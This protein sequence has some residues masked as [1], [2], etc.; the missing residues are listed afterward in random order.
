MFRRGAILQPVLLAAVLALGL[1]VAWAIGLGYCLSVLQQFGQDDWVYEYVGIGMDGTPFVYSNIYDDYQDTIY[2]TL[3]GETLSEE[4]AGSLHWLQG[5]PLA[6]PKG[7][8]MRWGRVGWMSRILPTADFRRP[9][10]YWYFVHSGRAKGTAYLV[11]YDPHSKLRVGYIGRKGFRRDMPPPE[12]R[13]P[14]GRRMGVY[15]DYSEISILADRFGYEPTSSPA[16]AV[17]GRIPPWMIYLISGDRLVEI[18]LRTHSVRDVLDSPGLVSIGRAERGVPSLPDQAT[19]QRPALRQNLAVRTEDQVLIVD[20]EGGQRRSYRLPPEICHAKFT[21]FELSDGTALAHRERRSGEGTTEHFLLWIDEAGKT[22]RREQLTLKS[23]T[24]SAWDPRVEACL[25]ALAIPSPL[26]MTVGTTV[27]SPLQHLTSGRE[28][29]Y[30]SA[31]AR[32][33]RKEW[34]ALALTYVLGALL[35]WVCS[36]RQR[37]HGLGGSTAWVVFVFLFG[38]PGLLGYLFCR[39]WP[40]R[41]ACPACG[42]DAPRDRETCFACGADF[43]EPVLKGTEVFA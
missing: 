19:E 38:L 33:L 21:F 29:T 24:P 7:P 40:A 6:G 26:A 2:H 17:P 5:A 16:A 25:P 13:F 37:R 10:T 8:R 4:Q 34:P 15:G 27:F 18:D 20:P 23:G 35:A 3:E 32:S 36:R 14:V 31:L 39:V 42:Q 30:R 9:P 12:E 28:R 41:L 11:G 43:P 1:G 22:L